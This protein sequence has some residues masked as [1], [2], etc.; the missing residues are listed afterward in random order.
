MDVLN[1]LQ[2]NKHHEGRILFIGCKEFTVAEAIFE[3][4]NS[5]KY[6]KRDFSFY[7]DKSKKGWQKYMT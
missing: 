5:G 6:P 7:V 1:I 2:E 4:V 3:A